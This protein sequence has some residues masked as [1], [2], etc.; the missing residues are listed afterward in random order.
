MHKNTVATVVG[1]NNP[2]T[3]GIAEPFN[4]PD[5]STTNR[6]N[7]QQMNQTYKIVNRHSFSVDSRRKEFELMK[8]LSRFVRY[9]LVF[10]FLCSQS[11][12][13]II[14]DMVNVREQKLIRF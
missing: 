3:L 13:D 14:M 11:H 8:F 12:L 10:D 9:R 2:N 6:Q 7:G 4:F 5:S 1:R